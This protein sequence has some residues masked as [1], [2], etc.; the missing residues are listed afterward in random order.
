M[1]EQ[2]YKELM[3]AVK[4]SGIALDMQKVLL[5]LIDKEYKQKERCKKLSPIFND[6]SVGTE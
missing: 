3:E 1:T 2:E 6:D 4:E 5:S